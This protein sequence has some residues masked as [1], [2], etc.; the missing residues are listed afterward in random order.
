MSISE[1]PNNPIDPDLAGTDDWH[2]PDDYERVVYIGGIPCEECAKTVHN[3][4]IPMGIETGDPYRVPVRCPD[5]HLFPF[6]F[7]VVPDEEFENL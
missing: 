7:E 6:V 2:S 4:P 5:D 1:N 3:I